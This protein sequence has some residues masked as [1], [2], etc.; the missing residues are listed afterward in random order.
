MKRIFKPI[1]VLSFLLMAGGAVA[2]EDDGAAD[3]FDI[4]TDYITDDQSTSLTRLQEDIGKGEKLVSQAETQDKANAKL[5]S[6]DKKGKQKKA[7]KKSVDAKS[8]RIKAAKYYEKSYESLYDIYRA[9]LGDAEFVFKSDKVKSEEYLANADLAMEEGSKKLSPY[10]RLTA[11]NLETTTYNKLKSDLEAVKSKFKE[12]G[13]NCYEAMKLFVSQQDKKSKEDAEEQSVWNSAVQTNTVDAYN[14]YI[15]KYPEGKY[16]SEAKRRI[17]A[18]QNVTRQKFSRPVSDDPNEGLAYRIQI[19]ADSKPW[20]QRKLQRLYKGNLPIEEKEVDGYYKY[21][22]GCF[23]SYSDAQ[24]AEDALH[25]K[26]S[27]I[28]CFNN[29]VQ[30]HVTEAQALEAKYED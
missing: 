8:L 24:A 25:L 21:W 6:S 29:G 26:Q 11:K 10:S 7:E 9:V 22:I 18:L 30:I 14:R 20:P 3:M 1:A 4:L 5:F 12:S 28:V 19:C 17:A 13:K 23:R 2:Q 27:F 15:S 16:V